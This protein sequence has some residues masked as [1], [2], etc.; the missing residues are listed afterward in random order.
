MARLPPGLDPVAV[1]APGAHVGA[2]DTVGLRLEARDTQSA[3]RYRH[4]PLWLP[5]I[6]L[7]HLVPPLC[8]REWSSAYSNSIVR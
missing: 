3:A 2:R 4:L 7:V 8:S 6:A 5:V 1:A